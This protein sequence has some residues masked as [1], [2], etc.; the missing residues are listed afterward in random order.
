MGDKENLKTLNSIPDFRVQIMPPPLLF[1]KT[2]MNK[3]PKNQQQNHNPLLSV[4]SYAADTLKEFTVNTDPDICA[5][6]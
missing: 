5:S 4:K 2:H 1:P 6:R 3:Q